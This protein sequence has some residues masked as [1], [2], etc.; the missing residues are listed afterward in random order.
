MIEIVLG[1]PGTGKTTTLLSLVEDALARGT[2]PDRIG[3][4]TFTKKGA[5]EAVE[6]AC[7]KFK[8]E[9]GQLPHFRTLHSLCYQQMGVHG[10]DMLVGKA[11]FEF[12]DFAKITVTGRAWSDD[13]LL[14]RFEI[15]DRILFMENLS[16]IR[17]VP[18]REQYELN[19]DNLPWRE[20]ERVAAALA[21]YKSSRGLMDYTDLLQEFVNHGDS[22][23][24]TELFVDEAQDLSA[25]QWKVVELLSRGAK[26]IVVAGDDDQAI[27]RWAG[28]DA[29]HLID[30]KGKVRVLNL[31]YRVPPVIQKVAQKIITPVKHRREKKWKPRTGG[32]GVVDRSRSYEDVALSEKGSILI[33][34]R[35]IYVLREQVEPALRRAGLLYEMK[36][37]SSVPEDAYRAAT[38]WEDIRAGRPVTLGAVRE[39]YVHMGSGVGVKRGQKKLPTFGD[40]EDEA[41]TLRDLL[42]HGGLLIDPQVPWFDALDRLKPED[43]SYMRAARRH[44]G[45]LRSGV[46]RIKLSTIHSIKGGQADHVVLMTEMAK[47]TFSEMSLAPD[48]ERRV[49]YVGVTRAKERL[50]VV[51]SETNRECPWL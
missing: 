6:R 38:T 47:R 5:A 22:I 32:R 11:F 16:R 26:R 10:G 44:G 4:V 25:L 19:N 41:V 29:E 33:L 30:M 51:G 3:Y 18:L 39:M 35:N 12:A 28:A 24:L 46:P 43:V 23:G 49:W 50:T 31:S 42:D 20:V 17:Q 1:P 21:V 40:D 34:S 15:G 36:G 13:G 8:L 7:V 48:D 37:K 45:N 14:S 27:F 2:P 9:R